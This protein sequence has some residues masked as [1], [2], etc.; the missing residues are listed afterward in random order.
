MIGHGDI[1]YIASIL[2]TY[3][4][5]FWVVVFVEYGLYLDF[6]DQ[7]GSNQRSKNKMIRDEW[8]E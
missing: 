2:Q 5:Y 3:K 6:I 7:G 1:F 8:L 4:L